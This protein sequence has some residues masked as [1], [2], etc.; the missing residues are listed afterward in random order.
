MTSEV[1]TRAR[2]GSSPCRRDT[3]KLA[4]PPDGS[5]LMNRREVIRTLGIGTITLGATAVV[6][7]RP[8]KLPAG[9][10]RRMVAT[11]YGDIATCDRGTGPAALFLHGFPLNAHQWRGAIER[12]AP[13]RRCIAPD[14]LGLGYTRVA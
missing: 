11:R 12:L 4:A 2:R 14:L 6:D 13:V 10:D 9:I 5:T 7:A 8:P 1:M 3:P